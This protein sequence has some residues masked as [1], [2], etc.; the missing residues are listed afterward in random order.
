MIIGGLFGF[1]MGVGIGIAKDSSWGSILWRASVAAYLSG[2]LFRWWGQI[3]VKGLKQAHSE[4]LAA[5]VAAQNL[6]QASNRGKS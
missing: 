4:K 6:K 1:T 3:W 5:A 2:L